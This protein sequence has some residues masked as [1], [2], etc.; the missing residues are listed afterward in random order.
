VFASIGLV[1]GLLVFLNFISRVLL[2]SAAWAANDLDAATALAQPGAGLRRKATEGPEEHALVG[3]R[4]RSDAGL[5]TFG[6]R[7][8]DR[9]SVAAGAVLGAFGAVLVG[10]GARGLRSLLR[11]H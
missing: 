10:T 2:V 11:R 6:Q 1:V 5:P 4:E 3:V 9:T 8:A 7:A